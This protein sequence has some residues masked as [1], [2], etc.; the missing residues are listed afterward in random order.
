M[1]SIE[2]YDYVSQDQA[3]TCSSTSCDIK[4]DCAEGINQNSFV[5]VGSPAPLPSLAK[6]DD[7]SA[8]EAALA[9]MVN[10]NQCDYEDL[11]FAITSTK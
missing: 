11:Q 9:D 5:V 2:S 1:T 4:I 7:R 8:A 10:A 3:V 6:F